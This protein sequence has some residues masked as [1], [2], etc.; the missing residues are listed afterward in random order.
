MKLL[1]RVKFLLDCK[2]RPVKSICLYC[3]V[4]FRSRA[5]F[6]SISV[7]LNKRVSFSI[8][9]FLTLAYGNVLCVAWILKHVFLFVWAVCYFALMKSCTTDADCYVNLTDFDRLCVLSTQYF[10][11]TCICLCHE[12]T[13]LD[14]V[15]RKC[16]NDCGH[17]LKTTDIMV[18]WCGPWFSRHN[19][20]A[21]MARTVALLHSVR[22]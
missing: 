10:R 13:S 2:V 18:E 21:F 4:I 5:L 11:V 9:R 19:D 6:S 20:H 16:T 3:S 12:E 7:L 22:C 15:Q 17:Q 14:L 8:S 1:S